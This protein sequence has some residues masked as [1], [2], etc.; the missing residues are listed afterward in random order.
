VT[1]TKGKTNALEALRA[2]IAERQQYEQWIATLESKRDGTPPHVFDKV[3]GDYNS[4][5]Q[6]VVGE[7]RSHSQELQTSI[8]TLSSQ[9]VEVAREEDAR[10]DALREA[11]LRAAVGEY[12]QQQWDQ[13][14][15]ETERALEKVGADRAA[16]ESQLG[17]LKGIQKLSEM[18]SAAEAQRTD[19][20]PAGADR[21]TAS[22]S[23]ATTPDSSTLQ[24]PSARQ[25]PRMAEPSAVPATAAS[26]VAGAHSAAPAPAAGAAAVPLAAAPVGAIPVTEIPPRAA[27]RE[28]ETTRSSEVGRDQGRLPL[29]QPRAP[30]QTP[31]SGQKTRSGKTPPFGG[32]AA[33][34]K[35]GDPRID[36]SKTLKCP[37]CGAPNYPTEWYC[38]KC[39][40]E[41]ATM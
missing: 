34:V 6:R 4:R 22:E 15:N 19:A 14:R 28:G 9:L 13:L 31:A 2:L 32:A 16:L 12:E 10:R 27:A 24:Q 33:K 3:N 37:E 20:A 36:Q 5:L 40:G 23:R 30:A 41:L 11:E 26:A 25:S 21:T 35:A 18:P 17:E 7:I 1:I 38:E 8:S 29:D 39:G